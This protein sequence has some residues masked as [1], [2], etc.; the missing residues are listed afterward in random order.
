MGPGSNPPLLSFRRL[1][2]SVLSIDAIV[3]SAIEYLE[4]D[5]GGNVRDLVVARNCCMARIMLPGKAEL[6]SE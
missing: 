6:V 1:G 4:I 3:D 2:I 5:S